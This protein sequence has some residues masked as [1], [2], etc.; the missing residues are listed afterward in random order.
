MP[1]TG[2]HGRC[3]PRPRPRDRPGASPPSRCAAR[4]RR[5]SSS[6]PRNRR[7]RAV[8]RLSIR[9]CGCEGCSP[10]N[11]HGRRAPPPRPG[12]HPLSAAA[13]PPGRRGAGYPRAPTRPPPCGHGGTHCSGTRNLPGQTGVPV[14]AR[15]SLRPAAT[16]IVQ[17]GGRGG[18]RNNRPG[19]RRAAPS[20]A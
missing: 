11:S 4:W 3:R 15:Q 6:W 16:G 17:A 19:G 14:A 5:T 2:R 13:A 7:T 8:A 10:L 18:H 12:Y 20:H 9:R 1:S